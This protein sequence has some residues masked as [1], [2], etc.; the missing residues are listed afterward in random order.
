MGTGTSPIV[1]RFL[2]QT[3]KDER[4]MKRAKIWTREEIDRERHALK[5]LVG[6]FPSIANLQP[7]TAAH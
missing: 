4:K 3:D 1:R 5:V 6:D 7:G 2:A